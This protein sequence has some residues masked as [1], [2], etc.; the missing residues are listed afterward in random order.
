MLAV[1]WV[2]KEEYPHTNKVGLECHRG[3][4]EAEIGCKNGGTY[5][6][7]AKQKCV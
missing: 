1:A 4:P 7:G 5:L 3:G 2:G 6:H